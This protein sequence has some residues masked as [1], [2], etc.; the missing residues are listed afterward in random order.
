MKSISVMQPAFIPYPGY[1]RLLSETETFVIFDDVQ[2]NRRW[3]SHRNR[4]TVNGELLWLTLPLSY[5]PRETK[6]SDIRFAPGATEEFR[7]RLQPFGKQ[8]IDLDIDDTHLL[9]YLMRT[10]HDCAK[11]LGVRWNVRLSS[12]L[13]IPP[14]VRGQARIIEICKRLGATDYLNATGGSQ[15]YKPDAFEAAGV[16]LRFLPEWTGSYGSVLESLAPIEVAA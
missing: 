14:E 16:K 13:C 4:L 6:I 9:P 8:P 15:L 7:K 2:F 11:L 10:L 1:F 5:H 3:F 12:A